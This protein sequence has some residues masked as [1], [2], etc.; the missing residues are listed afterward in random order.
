M[1]LI[2]VT[3]QLATEDQCLDFL[4]KMRCL[5]VC[6]VS[7]A[8]APNFPASLGGLAH[9]NPLNY[10]SGCFAQASLGRARSV[11]TE[12]FAIGN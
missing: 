2:D 10:S 7:R 5:M 4:E 6:A 3:K 11:V 1:N 12:P 8:R 9:P